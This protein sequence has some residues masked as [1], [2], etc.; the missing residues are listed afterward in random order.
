MTETL[1]KL[2]AQPVASAAPTLG[3][4]PPISHIQSVIQRLP[5]FEPW[6][7][8]DRATDYPDIRFDT[9][10]SWIDYKKSRANSS[11]K[12][13][14]DLGFLQLQDGTYSVSASN[15]KDQ[16]SAIWQTSKSIWSDLYIAD[17]DPESWG[18]VNS[19]IGDYFYARLASIHPEFRYC[20]NGKWKAKVYATVKYPDF[21]MNV[22]DKGKLERDPTIKG[23]KSAYETMYNLTI[24][25][26]IKS[27]VPRGPLRTTLN[28][29]QERSAKEMRRLTLLRLLLQFFRRFLL[30]Q[31]PV[32]QRHLLILPRIQLPSYNLL[33]P[34]SLANSLQAS[35]RLTTTM[36]L[37]P[38]QFRHHQSYLFL[39]ALYCHHYRPPNPFRNPSMSRSRKV[40][41]RPNH[42]QLQLQVLLS[43]IRLVVAL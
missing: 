32:L 42:L 24:L 43:V 38:H 2:I 12:A 11:Q 7:L 5:K 25:F 30:R 19:E 29:P 13:P 16:M 33:V 4:S 35:Y 9:L 21:T 8:L 39:L 22:R 18:L 17:V 3:V 1:E 15:S 27:F 36:S 6:D 10:A 41:P 37:R 31:A 20:N 14:H 26:L 34:P 28:L 23:A 40:Q